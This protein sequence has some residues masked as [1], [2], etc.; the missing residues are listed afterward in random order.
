[1]TPLAISAFT[2]TTA[3]G[4]GRAAHADAL[5]RERS[6]LAP[7]A[8][9]GCGLSTW[10]GEVAG[11]DAPLAGALA[12]WDCRNNR[13]AQ[14]ALEQD[15]F[16]ASV[17]RSRARHGPARVAV[18]IGTSTAGVRETERAYRERDPA[19]ATLP[20]WFRHR[21]T[22]NAFSA[23]DFVRIVLGLAGPACA[24]STACSS[25]MTAP[26]TRSIISASST[27]IPRNPRPKQNPLPARTR[28][29]AS[30]ASGT[31]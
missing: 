17:A 3:L 11:L 14:A 27:G 24:I 6:G 30:A 31:G 9:E 21:E 8:I 10:V 15:D 23:A 25:S 20:S 12:G 29:G 19:A 2:L 22:H 26:P 1:M 16:L 4:R 5:S 7:Q 18:F 13:L 28:P